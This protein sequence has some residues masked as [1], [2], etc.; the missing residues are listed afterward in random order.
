[1]NEFLKSIEFRH[2]CK[3][4]DTNKKIPQE[5]FKEILEVGRLSPSSFGVE[6]TRMVVVRS[7]ATKADLR[8]LCWNQEQITSA[9]EVVIYKTLQQQVIP[10]SAYLEGIVKKCLRSFIRH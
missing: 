6:P 10:P 3:L 7:E 4:F 9:S 2:A 1:M 5:T 8:P